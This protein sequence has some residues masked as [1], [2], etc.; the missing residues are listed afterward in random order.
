MFE[1]LATYFTQ[2]LICKYEVVLQNQQNISANKF[3][4]KN[5]NINDEKHS[6]GFFSYKK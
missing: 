4:V 6:A 5:N 3:A 1:C 2:Y